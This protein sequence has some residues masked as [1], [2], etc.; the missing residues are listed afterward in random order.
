MKPSR[1]LDRELSSWVDWKTVEVAV[2][3]LVILP[4]CLCLAGLLVAV[5]GPKG[6]PGLCLSL[7][8]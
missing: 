2:A 7:L 4:V 8:G 6:F 5:G 3:L 1:C